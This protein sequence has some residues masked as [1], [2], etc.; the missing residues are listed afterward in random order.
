MFM[1]FPGYVEQSA[2]G[3]ARPAKSCKARAQCKPCL[4]D[5]VHWLPCLTICKLHTSKILRSSFNLHRLTYKSAAL[6]LALHSALHL[7]LHNRLGFG[8]LLSLSFLSFFFFY[9][10]ASSAAAQQRSSATQ[11]FDQK[12]VLAWSIIR[13]HSCLGHQILPSAIFH[14]LKQCTQN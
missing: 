14:V 12:W 4:L 9:L 10:E 6:D 2:V 1:D 7:L 5:L 8:L 3:R 11:E 13:Y